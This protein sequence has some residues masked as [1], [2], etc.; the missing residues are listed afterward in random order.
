MVALSTGARFCPSR[1][2]TGLMNLE[3]FVGTTSFNHC[4]QPTTSDAT[5]EHPLFFGG[6]GQSH[7]RKIDDDLLNG[8]YGIKKALLQKTWEISMLK[9]TS[10]KTTGEFIF[11]RRRFLGACCVWVWQP[12]SEPRNQNHPLLGI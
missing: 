9:D 12:G 7:Q 2:L 8:I 3:S 5:L 4:Y 10:K 1:V 11:V 6:E